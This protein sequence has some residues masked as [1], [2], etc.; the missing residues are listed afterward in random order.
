MRVPDGDYTLATFVEYL[1]ANHDT[2]FDEDERKKWLKVHGMLHHLGDWKRS[3]FEES[4]VRDFGEMAEITINREKLDDGDGREEVYYAGE[5]R[6]G[7]LLFFTSAIQ[8]GYVKTLGSRVRRSRG[9][10]EAWIAPLLFQ[11]VWQSI[12]E[13]YGGFVYRF[14]SRRASLDDTPSRLRPSY[15]RRISYTGDDGTQAVKELQTEYG[16]TPESMY[17]RINPTLILQVTNAGFFA[18]REI[19]PLV[20]RILQTILDTTTEELLRTKE[21][22]EGMKFEVESMLGQPDLPLVASI[23]T[24]R[25]DLNSKPLSSPAIREFM[26]NAEGFSFIDAYLREGSLGFSAIV[27]DEAKDTVFDVSISD[28]MVT[29]VPKHNTTFESF[30]S[31]Y[32]AV[33]E[34]LAEN[35][36]LSI[37]GAREG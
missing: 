37:G 26:E 32:R 30:L 2:I 17:L 8:E 11:E 15:S 29:M 19:T 18:A 13:N 6:P 36:T 14:T 16:V 34:H 35:A 7:F 5:Y 22:S 21:V 28:G 1:L 25:I 4:E 12:L 24:G 3:L 23:T 9:I 33:T 27:V 31:F 20:F 10:T